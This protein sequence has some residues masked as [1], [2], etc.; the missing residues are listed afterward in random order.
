MVCSGRLPQYRQDAVFCPPIQF[1]DERQAFAGFPGAGGLVRGV[2]ALGRVAVR[3]SA[4]CSRTT[5]LGGATKRTFAPAKRVLDFPGAGVTLRCR[6]SWA[7]S[8]SVLVPSFPATY[9]M[10]YEIARCRG[11][12]TGGRKIGL[13]YGAYFTLSLNPVVFG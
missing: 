2:A 11:Q 1:R 10:R 5:G 7:R 4:G 13:V 8:R 6:C 3:W 9:A 12:G